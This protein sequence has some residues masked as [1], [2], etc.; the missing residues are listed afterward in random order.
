MSLGLNGAFW[1]NSTA[2]SARS[3]SRRARPVM[4]VESPRWRRK[5]KGTCD[6]FQRLP[7]LLAE[8]V[9]T[10]ADKQFAA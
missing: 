3:R 7:L 5:R 1:P 4:A 6:S 8:A 9:R 2:G 10:R